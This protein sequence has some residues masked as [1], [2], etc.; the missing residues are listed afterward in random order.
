MDPEHDVQVQGDQAN[1]S[2][3][4]QEHGPGAV[5]DVSSA[6]GIEIGVDGKRTVLDPESGMAPAVLG[7]REGIA[8]PQ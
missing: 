5:P 1:P 6:T 8:A 7:R 3:E 4:M 2:K